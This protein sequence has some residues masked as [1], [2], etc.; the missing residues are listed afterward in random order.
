MLRIETRPL[1][2]RWWDDAACADSDLPSAS[3]TERG[4]GYW[5]GS[6]A[7]RQAIRVCR[8]CPVQADCLRAQMRYE[9][10]GPGRH[11]RDGIFGGLTPEDRARLAQGVAR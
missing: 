10:S 5:G 11:A 7:H 8:G 3:W 2:D 1:S 9:A 6:L 4:S